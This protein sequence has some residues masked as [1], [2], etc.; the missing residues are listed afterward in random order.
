MIQPATIVATGHYIY[1][2]TSEAEARRAFGPIGIDGGDVYPVL[3]GDLAAIVSDVPN[4]KVRP[5]R[6]HM[7]AHHAVQKGLMEGG[8]LLPMS[9]GVIADGPD[10]VRRI[11]RLNREAFADQLRRVE[12]RLEMSLV[13]RYDVPS[14]FEYFVRTHPELRAFRDQLF[15][16]GR[17]PS[18]DD[19]IELGR[20]FDHLLRDDRAELTRQVVESLAPLCAEI[21]ENPPRGE[22]G[23]MNLA[24]LVAR[25][26]Q[27]PFEHGIFEAA[28]RFDDSFSFDYSGP[29]PP[30]NFVEVHLQT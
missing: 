17:Q 9:F 6:R 8:A 14:I 25:D 27:E 20:L 3:E 15:G 5:E 28:G 12:N 22:S 26:G 30:Y 16:G 2:I 29:W 7:A 4:G 13:V 10:A 23:V 11:L 18:E 1:A 21:K 19:K 24:C